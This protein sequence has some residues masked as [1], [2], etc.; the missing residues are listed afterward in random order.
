MLPMIQ[1]KLQQVDSDM[2]SGYIDEILR[3]MVE[4]DASD[5]YITVGLPPSIRTAD[6]ITSLDAAIL[7]P[8]DIEKI[9]NELLDESKRNEFDATL[10]LN[11]A[12]EWKNNSRFRVNFF[13]QQHSTGM[14]VRRIKTIV[15]TIESLHLPPICGKLAMKKK[16]LVLLASPSGSGKSTSV[17]AMLGHRNEHGSGHILT[18]EDPIEFVHEHKGCIFTQREVGIDTYSYGMA[19]RNALRQR[20]DVVVIGEIRDRETMEHAIN[21]AETGHLCIATIHSNNTYQAIERVINFFPEDF[22]K[23]ALTTLSQNLEAIISQKLVPNLANGRSIAIEILLNIGLV[24]NLIADGR[25]VDIR[26]HMEKQQ[27]HGMQTFDTDLLNLVKQGIISE[28][29]AIAEADNSANLK[30]RIKQYQSILKQ[31]FQRDDAKF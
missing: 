8:Q 6:K 15:P 7:T 24:K 14:V 1:L 19:L 26:E 10:E 17:A 4:Q 31:T 20:A 18:I 30:L 28:E 9:V 12:L 29:A 2:V 16:G 3:E 25:I 27:A 23:H 22:H 11:L 13:R 21:F 5:L